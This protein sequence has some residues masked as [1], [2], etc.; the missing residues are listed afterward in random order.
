VLLTKAL[1][2]RASR[3]SRIAWGI[4]DGDFGTYSI[5]QGRSTGEK[6]DSLNRR[7]QQRGVGKVKKVK[8]KRVVFCGG[9][10]I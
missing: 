9:K 1:Y 5:S 3:V 6:K 2:R 7:R 4:A 10:L 8:G